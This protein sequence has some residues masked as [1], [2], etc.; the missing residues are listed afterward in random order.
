MLPSL[1]HPFIACRAMLPSHA[2]DRL[3]ANDPYTKLSSGGSSKKARGES[4]SGDLA[5]NLKTLVGGGRDSRNTNRRHTTLSSR[6]PT[7]AG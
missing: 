7:Y 5:E 1:T 4:A 3:Y 6:L 2:T